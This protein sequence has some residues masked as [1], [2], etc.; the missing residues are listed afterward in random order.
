M[1]LRFFQF[2]FISILY[3]SFIPLS[4]KKLDPKSSLEN[5]YVESL[6]QAKSNNQKMLLIFE[7]SWCEDCNS[8]KERFAENEKI[9]QLLNENFLV[10]RVDIGRFDTNID[11]AQKFGSPQ[12]NGIPALVVIDPQQNDRILGTTKGGEFSNA[13]QMSDIAIESYLKQF[14]NLSKPIEKNLDQKPSSSKM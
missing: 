2:C 11:F 3:F 13:S 4:C 8:L 14:V 7:A 9:R 1:I 6:A 10:F 5:L 12:E